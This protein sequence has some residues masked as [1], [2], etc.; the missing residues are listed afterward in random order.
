MSSN[1]G[2]FCYVCGDH[3]VNKAHVRDKS[4]CIKAGITDHKHQNRIPMCYYHHFILLDEGYMGFRK[5]DDGKHIFVFIDIDDECKRKEVKSPHL[6]D[7]KPSYFLCKN[8][9]CITNLHPFI[10]LDEW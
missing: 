5:E 3:G 6:L 8:L 2:L 9:R 1:D 7:I 4:S 10:N